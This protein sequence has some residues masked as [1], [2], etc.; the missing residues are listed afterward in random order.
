[1]DA[2]GELGIIDWDG[3]GPGDRM[4]ELAY[5]T[6]GFA[7]LKRGSVCAELGWRTPPPRAE[8]VEL[9][10]TAYGLL[11]N[12]RPEL[13]DALVASARSGIDLGEAMHAEG[14]EPWA[15]LWAADGGA[16]DREDLA[17]TESVVAEW[18]KS[19]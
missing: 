10:R 4:A 7:P 5:C 6:A 16:G 8:R 11:D 17:V 19:W 13:A 2:S 12:K 15:S 9:F 1:V 18:R 3:I 14:R